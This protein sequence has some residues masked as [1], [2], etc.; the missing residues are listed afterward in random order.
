MADEQKVAERE[1]SALGEPLRRSDDDLRLPAVAPRRFAVEPLVP[2]SRQQTRAV[3]QRIT[4]P[5]SRNHGLG[6]TK[7]I[8]D[9][10]F[11]GML[12]ARTKRA[13]I[14]SAR[15]GRIDTSAAEAM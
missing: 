15:I 4:R 7:Y 2:Q 13:G 10:A 3:G 5:D 1:R 9:L 8:D 12:Y 6:Q 11:P 14:A